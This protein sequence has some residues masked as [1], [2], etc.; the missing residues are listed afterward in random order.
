M[1]MFGTAR[2]DFAEPSG[3]GERGHKIRKLRKARI[4]KPLIQRGNKNNGFIE[5]EFEDEE[6]AVQEDEVIYKLNAKAIQMDF[7]EKAYA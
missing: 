3:H 4:I 5:V 1:R 7:L 2:L 6:E